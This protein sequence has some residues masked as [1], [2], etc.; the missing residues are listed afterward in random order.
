[1]AENQ[2]A[3]AMNQSAG[4]PLKM[5]EEL[6]NLFRYWSSDR[7]NLRHNMPVNWLGQ[8]WVCTTNAYALV[9]I[10]DRVDIQL[11]REANT[12]QVES[13][14]PAQ[15]MRHALDVN[16][17]LALDDQIPMITRYRRQECEAC[18]GVGEFQYHGHS[19]DCQSCD[20]KGYVELGQ[21]ETI[22]DPEYFI[23]IDGRHLAM[24]RWAELKRVIKGLKPQQVTLLRNE[25]KPALSLFQIDEEV[26]V[27]LAKTHKEDLFKLEKVVKLEIETKEAPNV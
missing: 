24:D 2:E 16:K 18:E 20:E 21:K 13:I 8:E 9:L 23:E 5:R 10:K 22:Q 6:L 15:V 17:L 26:V 14:L 1:M 19:Y 12:P 3:R 7:P 25:E 4:L 11:E 27:V